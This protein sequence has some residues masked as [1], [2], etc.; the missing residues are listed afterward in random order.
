MSDML[1]PNA[2]IETLNRYF[3]CVMLPVN[4]HR[5]EV[6]EIMG[7]GVLAVFGVRP[8]AGSFLTRRWRERDSNSRSP[9]TANSVVAPCR[10]VACEG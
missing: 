7:D 10:W 3:D 1:A 2:V 6:M 4:R 8:R 5:G 9:A